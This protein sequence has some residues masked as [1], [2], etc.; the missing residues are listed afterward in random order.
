MNETFEDKISLYVYGE[1]EGSELNRFEAEIEEN[2]KLRDAV[3]RER[4]FLRSLDH[5]PVV[6]VSET[7]LAESRHD[8]MRQVY[9]EE[10]KT[11]PPAGDPGQNWFSS[12]ME[13]LSGMRVAWQPTAAVALLVLGFWGGRITPNLFNG[14]AAPATQQAGLFTGEPQLGAVESVNFD[15]Q[16][17]EVEIVVQQQRTIRGAAHDPLIRGLLISNV[18][19]PSSSVRL[20]TVEALRPRGED[21]EIRG[22]LI[23]AMLEDPNPGVRL[24]ALEALSE[25]GRQ[26]DVRL[27]LV[28]ALRTD[29][30]PG[31]RVQ[32]VDLLT[33]NPDRAIVGDLQEV[34]RQEPNTYVR[35]QCQKI[36]QDLN[37]SVDLY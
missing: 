27:A 33:A 6:D 15:R 7:L 26:E 35:L 13:S 11:A 17:G 23:Q 20:E 4:K 29:Q 19:S 12:F 3:E 24:K 25:H 10:R 16:Q 22:A 21:D 37:A 1:L 34:V 31:V 30:N 28:E 14:T 2:P 18:R 8:L 9:R 36:L 5:R 32:A